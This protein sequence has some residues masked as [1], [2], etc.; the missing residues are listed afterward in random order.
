MAVTD[1]KMPAKIDCSRRPM[2]MAMATATKGERAYVSIPDARVCVWG[3]GQVAFKI[4]PSHWHSP[5]IP[6]IANS[7]SNRRFV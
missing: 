1:M 2:E 6:A 7:K 5:N 3:G 4:L